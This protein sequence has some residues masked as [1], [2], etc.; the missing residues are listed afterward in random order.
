MYR[1]LI[2]VIW[3]MGF[4][5]SSQAQLVQVSGFILNSDSSGVI[6]FANIHNKK[7][8]TGSQA[9]NAGFY[10]VLVAVGDTVEV[11][12][13]GYKK[14]VLTLPKGFVGTAFHYDV[15]LKHITY[16][17]PGVTVYF[18]NLENFTREFNAM[19][20]PEDERYI[21]VDKGQITSRTPVS[22]NFGVT[23]NGPFSWLYNKFSRR[24]KE[25]SKLADLKSNQLEDYSATQRLTPKFISMATG[26]PEENTMDLAAYCDI[27][28]SA[29]ANYSNYDLI[30]ALQRCLDVYKKDRNLTDADLGIKPLVQDSVNT[31]TNTQDK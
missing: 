19:T 23:L 27:S 29:L 13:V 15:A 24:A 1:S 25:M 7:T 26:L 21:T 10:T 11:T 2:I 18:T 28:Q 4:V 9:T 12:A 3:A 6:S 31:N 14:S 16:D 8:K 22:N 5:L 30:F 20:I 17:L